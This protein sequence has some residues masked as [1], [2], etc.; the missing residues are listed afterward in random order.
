MKKILVLDNYDSFTYNLVHYIEQLVEYE[1]DVFRND[2]IELSEVANY[3]MI[4][5][6]PGPSLPRDAGILISL[7]QKFAPTKKILGVCLGMQAI[8]EVY[9]ADLENLN[10]VFHGVATT[11]KVTDRSEI[12]FN[13][14]A[15]TLEVG[16]Y[17]SWVVSNKNLPDCLKITSI[18]ENGC[19]MS[20][21]HKEFDL[22]GVQ[23]HPESVL[24][25]LGLKII[26]NW[27]R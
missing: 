26:E 4:V 8:A 20:L 27:L 19:I 5:L 3:E 14:I 11:I 6:S 10:E 24:T 17:H 9:G 12:L 7:I 1:V 21:R 22:C 13:N 15:D 25:P 18:D 16:R 2:E 23:F